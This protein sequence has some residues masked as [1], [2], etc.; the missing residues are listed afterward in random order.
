MN[1]GLEAQQELMQAIQNY[2]KGDL[3]KAAQTLEKLK[4]TFGNSDQ[5]HALLGT[6]YFGLKKYKD[7][8]RSFQDAVKL[9]PNN[10]EALVGMGSAEKARGRL[11]HAEMNFKKAL[12]LFPNAAELHYNIGDL[13]MGQQKTNDAIR[14]FEKAYELNQDLFP[15]LI[16]LSG[17]YYGQ[18]AYEKTAY[19]LELLL[20][21]DPS[22]Q[23]LVDRLNEVRGFLKQEAMVSPEQGEVQPNTKPLIRSEEALKWLDSFGIEPDNVQDLLSLAHLFT[24][25]SKH[26]EA[27]RIYQHILKVEP[28]NKNAKHS[29]EGMLSLKI[30]RWHFDMLADTKRNDAFERAINKVIN[31]KSRVLDIGTGSGLLS[32]M[33]A[34]SGAKSVLAC[35]V[36][37]EISKVATRIIEANGFK[38]QVKVVNKR[39]DHMEA[40]QD[41]TGKFSVIVSEI[42]DS[43]GLGEGV[44]P[45]LRYAKRDMATA[46]V[47]IIPAGISLKA[48]LIEL[49]KLHQVNPIKRISGFDLSIFDDFRVSDTYSPVNLGNQE[50]RA[51]SNVFDLRSYDFYN[52]HDHEIDFDNPEVDTLEIE[53]TEEGQIQAVAFWFD[54][55][56][57]EE[58]TY[59]SGPGGELD[60]WLQAVYFFETPKRVGKGDSISLKALYS[61]WMI[62]FRLASK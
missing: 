46:D 61:D 34:R 27:E 26:T 31:S 23:S 44:L 14:S 48:Q 35:E 17:I 51:L 10:K 13:F 22:N 53:A 49:P 41:Y 4:S 15:A 52:I 39:S 62:R 24:E 30:P 42:L 55:H 19:Y 7:A 16:Q 3:K 8:L 9:N 2:Q 11:D 54:L 38:D 37:P 20:E 25:Q 50:Y 32:M 29:L 43:G 47:K 59:S 1:E 45:S 21:K 33:A 56:M 36:N 60:H 6:V 58:D 5:V 12:A 18:K 28:G 40:G 57:D